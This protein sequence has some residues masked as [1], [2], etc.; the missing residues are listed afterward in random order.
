MSPAAL[1]ANTLHDLYRGVA[2]LV[3]I[4]LTVMLLQVAWALA[5][6]SPDQRRQWD[7]RRAERLRDREFIRLIRGKSHDGEGVAGSVPGKS[8]RDA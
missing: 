7:E 6:L 8:V 5:T 3:G 4:P 1:E 2:L